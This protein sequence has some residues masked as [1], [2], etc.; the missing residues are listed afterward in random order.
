MAETTKLYPSADRYIADV[1]AVVMDVKPS[2]AKRLL[3]HDGAFTESR[4]RD[5][6]HLA[7]FR[8]DSGRYVAQ[9]FSGRIA[10]LLGP[11][12]AAVDSTDAAPE[13]ASPVKEQ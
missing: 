4:P 12:S 1:P 9:D 3:A 6:E 10:D 7:E 11:D 13:P 8:D 5:A 2:E